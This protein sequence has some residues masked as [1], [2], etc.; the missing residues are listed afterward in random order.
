MTKQT[1]ASKTTT[2]KKL[3]QK[4]LSR[5]QSSYNNKKRIDLFTDV[6]K[7]FKEARQHH[8]MSKKAFGEWLGINPESINNIEQERVSPNIGH[9]IALHRKTRR[10]YAWILEGVE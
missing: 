6:N 2:T 1:T 8:N 10:S 9:I 7:R 3:I 5:R 4:N